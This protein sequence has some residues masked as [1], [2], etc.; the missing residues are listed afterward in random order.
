[1][2]FQ[3]SVSELEFG[4]QG[5]TYTL[6]INARLAV[7]LEKTIG[8]HP[9]T[10]AQRINAAS[11]KGEVPPLGQM[12]EFFEFM[13]KRAGARNVSFDDVYGELFGGD[14]AAD[15]G[16]SVGELLGVFVPA[17][18]GGDVDPKPSGKRKAAKK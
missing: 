18:D 11:V 2:G 16:Q 17:F 4:Y 8:M 6:S 10:L 12:A 3:F 14:N 9:L 13:L 15:I 7:D 5:A 1:M